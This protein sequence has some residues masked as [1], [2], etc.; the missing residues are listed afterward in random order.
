MY[1]QSSKL[2]MDVHWLIVAERYVW[3]SLCLWWCQITITIT[4]LNP[5][6]YEGWIGLNC[7]YHAEEVITRSHKCRARSLWL[8]LHVSPLWVET[9]PPP[10][11]SSSSSHC[12]LSSCNWCDPPLH[13]YDHY[14]HWCF[15]PAHISVFQP[16]QLTSAKTHVPHV[17]TWPPVGWGTTAEGDGDRSR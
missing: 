7:L 2:G 6:L 16:P 9:P 17:P 14:H 15:L 13:S 3:K 5:S 8:S 12:T 4:I 1:V 11:P 10:P